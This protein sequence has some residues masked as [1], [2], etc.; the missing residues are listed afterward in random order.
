MPGFPHTLIGVGPLCDANCEVTFIQEAVIE[1]NKQCKDILTGWHEATGP[2]L[3]RIDLQLVD[4]NLT[5]IPNDAKHATL[6]A[7]SAYDLPNVAALIGYSVQQQGTQSSIHGLKP[8]T[9]VTT[10]HGQVSLLQ[11]QQNISLLPMQP[12]WDTSS[13]NSRA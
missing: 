11:T 13:K 6:M 2:R 7:Y 1:R 9:M 5:S 12:S 10:Y 4:S 8:S 3:W